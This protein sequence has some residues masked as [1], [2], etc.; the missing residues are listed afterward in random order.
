[1]THDPAYGRK[2]RGGKKCS[3]LPREPERRRQCATSSKLALMRF[4]SVI[5]YPPDSL[6]FP[7]SARND[8][9]IPGPG[10]NV[11]ASTSEE[12]RCSRNARRGE[13]IGRFL[14]HPESPRTYLQFS[15]RASDEARDC[16]RPN[17]VRDDIY[18]SPSERSCYLIIS[19]VPRFT[20]CR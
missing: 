15:R 14:V 9:S 12:I 4:L 20:L 11:R 13:S 16:E 6:R 10:R 17:V 5:L 18:R 3:G 7:V 1:M 2:S 19:P 8:H